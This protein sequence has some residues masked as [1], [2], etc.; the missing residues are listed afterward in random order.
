MI[1]TQ[2]P[3]LPARPVGFLRAQ[4]LGADAPVEGPEPLLEK[5]TG[6]RDDNPPPPRYDRPG[7]VPGRAANEGSK[8]TEGGAKQSHSQLHGAI[9]SLT[10]GLDSPGPE[11]S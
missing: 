7:L 5:E 2:I 6:W 3:N 9:L 10:T 1:F 4:S 8:R 11:A